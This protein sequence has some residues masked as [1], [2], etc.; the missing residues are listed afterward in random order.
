MRNNRE[1]LGHQDEHLRLH[2]DHEVRTE[3]QYVSTINEL[4]C[5]KPSVSMQDQN[6][7]VMRNGHVP[8]LHNQVLSD[9]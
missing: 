2:Q 6:L 3:Q 7:F 9:V 8:Y 5:Q 1:Q 4:L